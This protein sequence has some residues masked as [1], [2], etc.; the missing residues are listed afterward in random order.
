MR[1][2]HTSDWHLGQRLHHRDRLDEQT[3][4]LDW[5]L[6]TIERERVDCLIVAGDIFDTHSPPNAARKLYFRFLAQ[7]YKLDGCRHVVFIGGNHDSAHHL[8]APRELLGELDLHV[9]GSVS[10]TPDEQLIHL[11]APTGETEAI[12]AAVP[13]LRDADLRRSL[14]AETEADRVERTRL[15]ILQHYQNLETAVGRVDC[16]GIPVIATGHLYAHGSNAD[17]EQENIYLSDTSNIEAGQFPDCF[18]YVALGH[19]HRPQLVG[20]LNHVRY[21]GSMIPLSFS[22]TKDE[23]QVLLLDFEGK[24]LKDIRPI[25]VPAQRRLKTIEG[26]LED[27]KERMLKLATDYA[28]QLEPWVDLLITDEEVPPNVR[29]DLHDFAKE[30]HCEIFKIRTQRPH[31]GAEEVFGTE[32]LDDLDT[33]DVF[34]RKMNAENVATEHR[35]GLEQS[36]L[37]LRDSL[38]EEPAAS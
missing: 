11:K 8:N 12:I 16:S 15:A 35:T 18:D 22:E 3:A 1:I 24:K 25:A 26:S 17:K 38:W 21:S 36:F 29:N 27:V 33:L 13:F 2:L 37:E 9:H 7:L 6:E 32:H 28:H 34:R 31:L 23:K 20:E 14:P 19:I 4:A 5:L 30:L 10:A